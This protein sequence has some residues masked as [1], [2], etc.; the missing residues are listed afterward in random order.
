MLLLLG[1]YNCIRGIT[2]KV[3][4]NIKLKWLHTP[5]TSPSEPLFSPSLLLS[6]SHCRVHIEVWKESHG[7]WHM[8]DLISLECGCGPMEERDCHFYTIY[9][10]P[11][12]IVCF[13]SE[14]I[15]PVEV[16]YLSF[17]SLFFFFLCSPSADRFWYA[18][19]PKAKAFYT[20]PLTS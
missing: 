5:C 14:E 20:L 1:G 4:S 9:S 10:S 12:L 19:I 11:G 13:L 16:L 3:L 15:F 8:L 6:P 2:Y 18:F 17:I 7:S